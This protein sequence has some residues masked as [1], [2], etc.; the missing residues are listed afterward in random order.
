MDTIAT[1]ISNL[2]RG[3]ALLH[4]PRLNKGTA[5]TRE[6]RA[7]LGLEGLLPPRVFTMQEQ[8]ER[9]HRNVRQK[10]HDLDR[11]IFLVGLQDRNETLFYRLVTENIVEMMP[12]LYTPT[13]GEACRVFG[14]IFRRS[15]GLYISALNRGRIRDVLANWPDDDIRVIV[16]TDGERILGLGDLGAYGMGIPIGKLA[17]YTACAGI[18]PAQCLPVML[19]VGT[20]NDTLLRDPFYTGIRERRL[21]GAAYD[22]LIDEFVAAVQDR[23][24]GA[25]LQWEDF[26]TDNAFGLLSRYRNRI[27]TFNDD[28]QGTAAVT[29]AALMGATRISRVPLREQRVLFYGAGASA[30]G[31]A[32]LIVAA[33]QRQGLSLLEARGR[34]W[35]FDRKGLVTSGRGELA[36]HKQPY[37]HDYTPIA[38]FLA[39]IKAI[40]P[41]ALI[42]LSTQAQAFSA[43]VLHAMAEIQDR[44]VIF[45]LSNPTANAECTAEQA[46]RGTQG[47]AVFASGSPFG[48]VEL[49]GRRHVPRQA[50]NAYVFPGIGLG[51]VVSEARRVTD[52]MFLA[53]ADALATEVTDLEIAQGSVLPALERIRRSSARVA[54]EVARIARAEGLN[55]RDLPE[56]IEGA[57]SEAMYRPEY[58]SYV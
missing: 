43:E 29:L 51:V 45:A 19:D 49:D 34:C 46:Y 24:P 22:E 15:R 38:D 6:E 20:D 36:V 9:V 33:M 58:R 18:H 12:L 47:R 1:T 42:G 39:V 53:A 41:T 57:V 27:C 26:A 4:D 28:I 48:E 54:T 56:D 13:V 30:T 55:E 17:L 8:L 2:P 11:Y 40:R 31:V 7:V 16:A 52:T 37:G 25:M 44:P 35:L 3:I 32:D 5:F 14:H 21:R 10:P 23:Y 50:N